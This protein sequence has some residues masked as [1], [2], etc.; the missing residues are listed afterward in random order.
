MLNTMSKKW[1]AVMGGVSL[2]AVISAVAF[3]G[4]QAGTTAYAPIVEKLTHNRLSVTR[5]FPG[6]DGLLG[7]V[8]EGQGGKPKTIAWGLDGKAGPLLILGPVINAEGQN[9]TRQAMVKEHLMSKPIP[10]NQLAADALKAPGFVLGHAGPLAAVFMDPDCIFC[11]KFYES[12]LPDLKAGTLRLKVIPVAF[13]KRSSL[14]KAV[15]ILS[16]NDPTKAWAVN[17]AHFNVNTEEGG[18]APATNLRVPVAA[19]IEANTRLLG[20]TGMVA[21]PTLVACL[22]G[23]DKPVVWHGMASNVKADIPGHLVNLLPSG[24]CA[25]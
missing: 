8:A 20:R 14:P 7:I 4:A 19:Q 5:T 24:A 25:G 6:P 11:H 23:A 15:T 9:L 17:E 1:P 13:L 16:S 2:A 12:V 21:T 22:K 18:I 10:A 3:V